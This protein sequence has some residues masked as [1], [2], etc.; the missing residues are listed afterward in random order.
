MIKV[1]R[2]KLSQQSNTDRL[3]LFKNLNRNYP[4]APF[5]LKVFSCFSGNLIALSGSVFVLV[6]SLGVV[7][8]CYFC[9]GCLL[10]EK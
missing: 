9:G 1:Q 4:F 5:L 8:P 3:K 6:K 7:N 10:I 2:G